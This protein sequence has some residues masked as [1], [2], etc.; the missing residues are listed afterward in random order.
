MSLTKFNGATNNIRGLVDKPTQSALQLK[1]LFDKTG[2][3]LKTYINETLTTEI[4]AELGTKANSSNVY[5]KSDVYNKTETYN[6]TEVDNKFNDSGWLSLSISLPA[7]SQQALVSPAIIGYRKVG[8]I[9]QVNATLKTNTESVASRIAPNTVIATLPSGYRPSVKIEKLDL[10]G[11]TGS[12]R[13]TI[14]TNGEIIVQS[15]NA[16]GY[17]PFDTSFRI[18]AMY[19]V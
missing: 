6:K 1:T 4:D 13:L 5:S 7:P 15:S 11:N 19:M 10:I 12:Y 8:K 16:G 14:G 18:N 2:D 3:D 17:M 9:V